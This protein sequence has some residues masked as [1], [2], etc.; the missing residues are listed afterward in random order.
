MVESVGGFLEMGSQRGF[1]SRGEAES[2]RGT[3]APMEL[4]KYVWFI[5]S[6]SNFRGE[7]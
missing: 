2:G 4:E 6:V 3:T 7:N 1:Q 5:G